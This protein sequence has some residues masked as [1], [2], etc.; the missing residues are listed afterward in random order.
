MRRPRAR[1]WS[2][3]RHDLTGS[4]PRTR[5]LVGGAGFESHADS[6]LMGGLS[7][8]QRRCEYRRPRVRRIKIMRRIHGDDNLAERVRAWLNEE[9]QSA[10][11][12]T[13][14]FG[15]RSANR[16]HNLDTVVLTSKAAATSAPR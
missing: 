3:D 10:L 1:G 11:T 6:N 7:E 4:A 16:F 14:C 8:H 9:Q 13:N 12:C 5:G 15:S 2:I